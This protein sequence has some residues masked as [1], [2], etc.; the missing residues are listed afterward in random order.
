MILH[1]MTAPECGLDFDHITAVSPWFERISEW[2]GTGEIAQRHVAQLPSPRVFKTHLRYDRLEPFGCRYI[3]VVRDGRDVAKSNYH[4]LRHQ[5]QSYADFFATYF[6]PGTMH[7]AYGS[8]FTHVAD[9]RRNEQ[10]RR[11]LFVS[12][13]Q[14]RADLAS[15]VG[16]IAR[17][18]EL[19]LSPARVDDVVRLCSFESMKKNEHKFDHVHELAWENRM[20]T[21]DYGFVRSGR[22]A[23]GHGELSPG[24][25]LAYRQELRR[26]GLSTVVP[27]TAHWPQPAARTSLDSAST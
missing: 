24:H 18:C 16:R 20:V 13:E 15:E 5:A 21:K 1:Q 27:E 25:L 23:E 7:G 6:L 2:A 17:F 19:Q 9:W 3:Y 11:V 10:A 14:L 4:F 12:Y 8:W 26:F 22:T